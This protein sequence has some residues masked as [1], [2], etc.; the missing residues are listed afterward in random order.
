MDPENELPGES[1]PQDAPDLKKIFEL[2]Q[3]VAKLFKLPVAAG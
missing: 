1:S 2:T 3:E